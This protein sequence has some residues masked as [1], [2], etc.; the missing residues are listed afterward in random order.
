MS[1]RKVIKT[2]GSFPTEEA[3]IKLLYLAL[4]NVA[5]KWETVQH[6]KQMLNYLDMIGGDRIREAG[7]RL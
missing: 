1:L 5:A 4:T 2:R 6:W 3:A 7:A